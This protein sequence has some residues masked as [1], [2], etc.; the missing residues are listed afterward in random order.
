MEKC[1]WFPRKKYKIYNFVH[2]IELNQQAISMLLG[3]RT[4]VRGLYHKIYNL[5]I[6]LERVR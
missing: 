1:V 3:P 5:Y 2:G 6:T 4:R